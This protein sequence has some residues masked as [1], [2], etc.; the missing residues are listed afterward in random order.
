M[1]QLLDG[2][3]HSVK[4]ELVLKLLSFAAFTGFLLTIW[5]L[6]IDAD[7]GLKVIWYCIIPLAPLIFLLIPNIWTVL[8]PLVFMQS[9][10]KRLGIGFNQYLNKRQTRYLNITG[11]ILLYFLV[12]ARFFIFN[13]EGEISFYTLNILLLLAFGFGFVFSGLGGWC[14]GLCPIRPVELMYSQMN[15]EKNRPEICS[16]CDLCVSNCP[17]LFVDQKDR[18]AEYNGNFNGFIYSFPG[19]IMGYY[20]I[21]PNELFYYIYLKI[22]TFAFI[23][24]LIFKLADRFIKKSESQFSAIII[25]ILLYYINTLPSVAEAW[26]INDRFKPLLYILPVGAIL[27]SVING[28]PKAYRGRFVLTV[29]I[30]ASIFLITKAGF[31]RK[32]FSLNHYNWEEHAYKVGDKACASCHRD[33][34]ESY[35]TSEMGTSFSLMSN[36]HED[37]NVSTCNV[38]DKNNELRYNIEQKGEDYFMTEER[39]DDNNNVTHFLEFKI[40]YVIGS[41][42]N[43]KSFIMKN[44]GYFFEMPVTWYSKK[45]MWDLSP[46]YERYNL[47]FFRETIQS[48]I[49]CHTEETTFEQYS[50]NR[51]LKVNHG[52]DCE[53]CHGPGSLHV[54]RYEGK[55]KLGFRAILNPEKDENQDDMVCYDCHKKKEVDFLEE[56]DSRAIRFTAHASRLSLSKCFTE[57]GITCITCHDVHKKLNKT[58]PQL[59]QPCLDCH[60]KI[61]NTFENHEPDK[62]CSGCHMPGKGSTDIPHL[63]PTEHWI[64][65]WDKSSPSYHEG[66]N[67]SYTDYIV[68]ESKSTWEK[69]RAAGFLRK[70]QESI[71][72]VRVRTDTLKLAYNLMEKQKFLS[73]DDKLLFG[74]ILFHSRKYNRAIEQFK[75]LETVD[76][77]YYDPEPDFYMY[78]GKSYFEKKNYYEAER[79][80][81]RALIEYPNH[82]QTLMELSRLYYE[83]K[84][85]DHAL[86]Y[87]KKIIDLN[88]FYRDALYQRAFLHQFAK[89]DRS[90]A[91]SGYY[92]LLKYFPDDHEGIINAALLEAETGNVSQGLLLLESGEKRHP[93]SQKILANLS[94]L[95]FESQNMDR[96]IFYMNK[97]NKL[98][99]SN[100]FKTLLEKM[101]NKASGY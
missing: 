15:A 5:L 101:A 17:R 24:Y 70:Y 53:K 50:T 86:A 68:P 7:L 74:K 52:I 11:I 80:L 22:F 88:P 72:T 49:D 71:G 6:Y 26:Y 4:V 91:K 27:F 98:N 95:N 29:G 25:S 96:G 92:N 31:D 81:E 78:F 16:S 18:I 55:K 13:V 56:N 33:I 21:Q 83:Q 47:R 1:K 12:P 32:K 30:I 43:T 44:N 75:D 63:N 46:G 61:L 82:L 87:T 77:E 19:F 42:N 14:M 20:I 23:S 69:K 54:A 76:I 28:L 37:L 65:V 8:C 40:D 100:P 45:K 35:L 67:K 97:L 51:F 34:Y 64:K 60:K 10:P 79:Y 93:N 66:I 57:G 59:N 62:N 2:N 84:Q 38:F 3:R 41:G 36:K 94:R 89:K 90:L 48:C 85:F 73:P 58:I 99:P 9:I 39:V